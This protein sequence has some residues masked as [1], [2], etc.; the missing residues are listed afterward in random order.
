[1]FKGLTGIVTYPITQNAPVTEDS[2]ELYQGQQPGISG[3]VLRKVFTL[4]TND[5]QLEVRF[6]LAR[7]SKSGILESNLR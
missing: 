7:I 4:G 3:A 6:H 5:Y 1:M 2:D